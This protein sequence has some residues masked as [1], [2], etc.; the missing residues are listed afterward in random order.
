MAAEAESLLVPAYP[1]TSGS[2]VVA[3]PPETQEAIRLAQKR[4]ELARLRTQFN[5][6]YPDVVQ[7][8]AEI[9]AMERAAEDAAKRDSR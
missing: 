1:T 5:D 9:K 4:Q 7:L 3:G 6:R 2:V 8:T